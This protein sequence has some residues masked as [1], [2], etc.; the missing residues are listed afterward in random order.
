MIS[1]QWALSPM[2]N[3]HFFLQTMASTCRRRSARSGRTGS[4]D[5]LVDTIPSAFPAR[6]KQLQSDDLGAQV[7]QE[8]QAEE[9]LNSCVISIIGTPSSALIISAPNHREDEEVHPQ[10]QG[11]L[12]RPGHP[13]AADLKPPIRSDAVLASP[14]GGSKGHPAT[15]RLPGPFPERRVA[16]S[17]F[18][19]SPLCSGGRAPSGIPHGLA[20]AATFP[21]LRMTCPM[22]DTIVY[23]KVTTARWPEALYAD[24]DSGRGGKT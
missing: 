19:L 5:R 10:G 20:A 1:S 24:R 15:V 21:C 22:T 8:G 6:G 18:A 4:L 16:G 13:L 14:Y 3:Q 11:D 9:A 12:L 2:E 23:T 17:G 7:A